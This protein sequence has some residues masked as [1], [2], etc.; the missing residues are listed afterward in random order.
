MTASNQEILRSETKK[1]E[2]A[3]KRPVYALEIVKL[4][5]SRSVGKNYQM[6]SSMWSVHTSVLEKGYYCSGTEAILNEIHDDMVYEEHSNIYTG[7]FWSK[8]TMSSI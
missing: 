1:V 5:Y 2:T 3:G 6:S 7:Q 4:H 8:I